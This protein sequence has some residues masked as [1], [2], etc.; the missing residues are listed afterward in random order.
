MTR[1]RT[2]E[3]MFADWLALPRHTR[4]TFKAYKRQVSDTV[5][6]QKR[7]EYSGSSI[8]SDLNPSAP[9][10]ELGPWDKSDATDGAGVRPSPVQE[11][12]GADTG[13]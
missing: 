7:E 8:A 5:P 1:D 6:A 4:T 12:E 13:A 2:Y 10:E 11:A 3:Q 9:A